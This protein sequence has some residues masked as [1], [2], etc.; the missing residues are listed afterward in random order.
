[1]GVLQM[2]LEC[3]MIQRIIEVREGGLASLERGYRESSVIQRS[4]DFKEAE[5]TSR[6]LSW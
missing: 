6:E 3:G 1:M 5:G 4:Q 2:H